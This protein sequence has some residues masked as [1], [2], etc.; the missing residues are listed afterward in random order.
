MLVPPVVE[1]VKLVTWPSVVGLEPSRASPVIGA[2]L[3]VTRTVS[4]MLTMPSP[5]VT[6]KAKV[7]TAGVAGAVKVGCAV[8]APVSVTA[9]VPICVHW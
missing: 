1:A 3:T 4:R 5:S 2:S 8:L 6:F 9:G 7:S